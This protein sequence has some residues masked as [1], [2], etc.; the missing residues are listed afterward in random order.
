MPRGIGSRELRLLGIVTAT[1]NPSEADTSHQ[2]PVSTTTSTANLNPPEA[3]TSHQDPVSS[4]KSTQE[5]AERTLDEYVPKNGKDDTEIVLR[6]FLESLPDDGRRN[7]CSDIIECAAK[8]TLRELRGNLVTALLL[9]STK[10]L[11]PT[12]L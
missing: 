5:L 3:D 10:A 2:D 9:P 12:I 6:S 4:T 7:I 11:D 8:G 1:P